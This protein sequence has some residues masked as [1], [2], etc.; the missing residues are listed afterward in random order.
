MSHIYARRT[1]YADEDSWIL[2]LVDHY[3][4]RGQLWRLAEGHTINFYDVPVTSYTV[5]AIYD[6]QAR[7]YLALGMKNEERMQRFN[8]KASPASTFTPAGLRQRGRR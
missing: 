6:L 4:G 8:F 3:D 2:L 5:E 7:R 1:L